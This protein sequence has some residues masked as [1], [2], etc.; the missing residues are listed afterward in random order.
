MYP[1]QY[2]HAQRYP[3][4]FIPRHPAYKDILTR[5]PPDQQH[6]PMVLYFISLLPEPPAT[7][8]QITQCRAALERSRVLIY[9]LNQKLFE[10]SH[11]HAAQNQANDLAN[12]EKT[13]AELQRMAAFRS[14]SEVEELVLRWWN[15]PIN[16]L[17]PEVL[18]DIFRLAIYDTRGPVELAL[19]RTRIASVCHTWREVAVSDMTLW[20][21]IRV[22]ENYPWTMTAMQVERSGTTFLDIRVDDDEQR[23]RGFGAMQGDKWVALINILFRK[24]S[25]IRMLIV[26]VKDMTAMF[27]LIDKLRAA[28]DQPMML[29]RLELFGGGQPYMIMPGAD[30]EPKEYRQPMALFDGY[31][32]PSLT[33]LTLKGVQLDWTRTNFSNLTNF[34]IRRF[35]TERCPTVFKFR[36]VLAN[37]PNLEGLVVDAAAP[38]P[39]QNQDE[40]DA[41]AVP[42]ML[43]RLDRLTIADLVPS[44]AIQLW[45]QFRAPNV[46]QLTLLNLCTDDYSDFIEQT[47]GCMPN[48]RLLTWYSVELPNT[49]RTRSLMIKWFKAMPK[50]RYMR[51]SGLDRVTMDFFL[52]D[53][54]V[55]D[56]SLP[57]P[58]TGK[59]EPKPVLPNLLAIEWENMD[60]EDVTY[61]VRRRKQ[62]GV[63]LRRLYTYPRN[64]TEVADDEDI[65]ELLEEAKGIM[66]FAPMDASQTIEE[67][68]ALADGEFKLPER[69]ESEDH[70][71]HVPDRG[72][73]DY[74]MDEDDEDE[75][76]VEMEDA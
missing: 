14:T 3:L 61:F 71:F 2:Y 34:D 16:Q 69:G 44:A 31:D 49:D 13:L 54:A 53:E 65:P 60:V 19:T 55:A 35:P 51:V 24:L 56:G 23:G 37:C 59:Y 43:P 62:L 1:A 7:E 72:E 40:L 28:K 11:L 27:Y 52:L 32:V 66:G 30:F 9:R 75:E 29:E 70:M 46:K 38:I 47:I 58:M 63:P 57:F 64:W 15:F 8:E 17:P 18:A 67:A 42:I 6:E 50:L 41:T 22:F 10:L 73:Q 45:N 12:A 48:V 39:A 36:E 26:N 68:A 76:D 5:Y 4:R 33:F 20:N 25:Q 74:D 21:T